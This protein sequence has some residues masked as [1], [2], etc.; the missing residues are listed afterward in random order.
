MTTIQLSDFNIGGEVIKDNETYRLIDNKTLKNLV[1]SQ[2][3]L[4]AGQRT[5]G[6]SHAG[7]EEVYFFLR[8]TGEMEVGEQRFAVHSGSVILI[9][10]GEFHRVHNTGDIDLIFNCVFDGKRNH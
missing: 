4:H 2:T 3:Q 9:P 7:Q 1:L 10:D 5:R 8:G 6:H